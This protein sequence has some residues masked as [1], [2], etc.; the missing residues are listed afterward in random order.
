VGR[1]QSAFNGEHGVVFY[2]IGIF[3]T[4]YN[5]YGFLFS[6]SNKTSI[7]AFVST[8]LSDYRSLGLP[9]PTLSLHEHEHGR[10]GL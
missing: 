7:A 6:F 10:G 4:L 1:I 9:G 5:N 3:F 8:F 2:T